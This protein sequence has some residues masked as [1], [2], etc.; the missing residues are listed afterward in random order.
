MPHL[1]PAQARRSRAGCHPDE[2]PALPTPV[3]NL[4]T[5]VTGP[6][7]SSRNSRILGVTSEAAAKPAAVLRCQALTAPTGA[8]RGRSSGRLTASTKLGHQS[9]HSPASNPAI[10]PAQQQLE[11]Q[12][13]ISPLSTVGSKKKPLLSGLDDPKSLRPPPTV[14]AHQQ[15]MWW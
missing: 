12:V 10:G 9:Q 5:G 13:G 2:L 1:N 8:H 3:E 11:Q 4:K 15:H 6:K 14:A 7:T